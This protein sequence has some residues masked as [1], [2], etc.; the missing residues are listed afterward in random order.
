MAKFSGVV[1]YA[2]SGEKAPG[3]WDDIVTKKI[4]Y[5]DVIRNNRRWAPGQ[6]VND[7]MQINN[8]ISIIGDD[9]AHANWSLMK[10]VEYGGTLWSITNVEIA[11]P[12]LILTLGSV[13]NGPKD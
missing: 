13:Y 3:V 4:Y 11:R 8:Q 7:N 5:G 9:F 10:F 6:Q 2:Q 1:G 12:R